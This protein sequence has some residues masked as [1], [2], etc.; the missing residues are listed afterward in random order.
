MPLVSVQKIC[1]L[2]AGLEH[3]RPDLVSKQ[4]RSCCNFIFGMLCCFI[5]NFCVVPV[6]SR[7]IKEEAEGE[8]NL[9]D[10]A[11]GQFFSPLDRSS[12]TGK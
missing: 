3:S 2:E 8:N 1:L 4:S 9:Q 11:H 12:I 5:Q 7:T 6:L 10:L